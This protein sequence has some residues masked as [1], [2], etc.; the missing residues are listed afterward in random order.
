MQTGDKLTPVNSE[1]T[2]TRKRC[3]REGARR[4]L[5]PA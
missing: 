3:G 4:K 1:R 5:L 2:G